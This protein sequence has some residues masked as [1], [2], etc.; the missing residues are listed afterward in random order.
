[1]LHHER[2][3]RRFGRAM[4]FFFFAG[5]LAALLMRMELV[6]PAGWL[7][8]SD[9]F[10]KLFSLHG[11]LMVY[12]VLLPAFPALLGLTSLP[13]LTGRTSFVMPR[14]NSLAWWSYGAGALLIA[15]AFLTGGVDTGWSFATP[16]ALVSSPTPVVLAALGVTGSALAI[17]LLAVNLMAT[18]H[19]RATREPWHQGSLTVTGLYAGALA[20]LMAAPLLVV[21]MVLLIAERAFGLPL[22]D[23]AHGGDPSILKQLFWAAATPAVFA[24]ILPACGAMSDLL[25]S[26]SGARLPMRRLVAWCLPAVALLSYFLWG[27]HLMAGAGPAE[28]GV[29]ALMSHLVAVPLGVVLLSWM[30][31]A[32]RGGW[33]AQPA[34]ALLR[35]FIVLLAIGLLTGLPLASPALNPHLH[36]SVF[37]VAHMH[38]IFVGGALTA[39]LAIAVQHWPLWTGRVPSPGVL[40]AAAWVLLAGVLMTFLPLFRLGYHGLPRR[41]HMYPA[42]FNVL[43][44]LATAG[45]TVLVVALVLHAAALFT[46]RRAAS[47]QHAS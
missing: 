18:T 32:A 22:F 11:M 41:H 25:E 30:V 19:A 24:V 6:Q 43:Q 40:R 45:A 42:E 5:I 35:V 15:I 26:V 39:L 1:M 29:A 27:R 10:D 46:A 28:A 21:T 38:L 3:A 31:A 14:L 4:A 17:L 33:S 34:S 37:V 12:F 44:V 8:Q 23:P 13:R 36:N 16:Y 9:T 2:L 7:M 20:T 47:P